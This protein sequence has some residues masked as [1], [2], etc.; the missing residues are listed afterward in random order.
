MLSYRK[1]ICN[2]KTPNLFTFM[3]FYVHEIYEAG[4]LGGPS[5]YS[6]VNQ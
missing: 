4:E 6:P 2:N 3:L 1:K 5:F